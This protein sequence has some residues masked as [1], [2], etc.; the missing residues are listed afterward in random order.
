VLAERRRPYDGCNGLQRCAGNT[1]CVHDAN[2]NNFCAVICGNGTMCTAGHNVAMHTPSMPSPR[3]WRR[4]DVQP[5]RKRS[6]SQRRTKFAWRGTFH[7]NGATGIQRNLEFLEK[8]GTVGFLTRANTILDVQ[9]L[10]SVGILPAPI[11]LG[12]PALGHGRGQTLMLCA[13]NYGSA[14][15]QFVILWPRP[16]LGDPRV[17]VGEQ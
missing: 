7:G 2:G 9:T 14:E 13:K 17:S 12:K 6:V 15:L 8:A 4:R 16:R 1:C 3:V 11:D 10:R 5:V